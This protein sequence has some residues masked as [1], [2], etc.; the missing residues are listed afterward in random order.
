MVCKVLAETVTTRRSLLRRLAIY[1]DE[2]PDVF[3]VGPTSML[4]ILDRFTRALV[5][6]GAQEEDHHHPPSL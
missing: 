4:P 2:H 6:A 5:D 1:M 3:S